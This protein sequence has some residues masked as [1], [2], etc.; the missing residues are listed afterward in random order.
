M[1]L[2]VARLE[3]AV[4]RNDPAAVRAE[5]RDASEAERKTASKAL[6]DLFRGPA[7]PDDLPV[8][9]VQPEDLAGLIASG[10]RGHAVAG[11]EHSERERKYQEWRAVANGLA[12]QL[13]VLG[14]S[15]GVA[16]AARAAQDFPHSYEMTDADIGLAA[17]LL[18]DRAPGWL[19]DLVDRHL[20]MHGQYQLGIPAWPLARKL[21][22]LGAITRPSV[23]EYTTLLPGGLLHRAVGRG[24]VQGPLPSPAQ[25]LLADPG[26]L[27]EEVWRLFTVPDAG[28][29]LEQ[30][31]R[32][33]DWMRGREWVPEQTW[34][35]SL[36]QLSAQGHLA[37]GR[38]IDACL[39]AFCRDF[40]PHR[41]SWYAVTLHQLGPSASE[42]AARQGKYLS[43]LAAGSKA[44]ISIGQQ[45]ARCLL[46]AGLLDVWRLL[47]ASA[48][49]LLF[50]QKS[51]AAAQLKLVGR[52]IAAAP[53]AQPQAVG[54]V[55]LAF[56]HERQD[57][58]E[59]ALAMIRKHGIPDGAPVA[60]MRSHAAGL[61]PSLAAEAAAL[62]LGPHTSSLASGTPSGA[63]D[64]GHLQPDTDMRAAELAVLQDRIR[65]LPGT[66]APGP[67]AALAIVTG[68]DVPGP[69]QVEAAAGS[70]LP[71]PVTDTGELIA[72]LTMLLEDAAD[73]IAVERALAGA[74]RLS[75]LPLRQ[76]SQAAAP[77]L[78]RAAAVMDIYTPFSG[79]RLTSDIAL[80]A[81]VW[82]S[83]QLPAEDVPRHRRWHMPGEFAVDSTGRAL[84][85]AGIF[86]ARAWEAARIIEAGHGGLLLAEP[87]SS[88]GA[89]TPDC[90]LERLQQL[91]HHHDRTGARQAAGYDRD[92][93]LLRLAPSPPNSLWDAW[94]QVDGTSAGTL[95]E[96]HR[97]LQT[98]LRFAAVTGE[99]GGRPL[100]G[101]AWHQH[102]LA[103]TA[104]RVPVTP[105]CAS[106]QLLTRLDDP[107]GDH[108]ELAG[109]SRYQRHYGAMVAGWTLACPWQPEL[110]AAH[111]LRPLCDGLR[112]GMSPATTAIMSLIDPGHP[113]GPVGHLALVT[114]LAS[115]EADT[116][117]AAAELWADAAADGRLQPALAAAAVVKGVTGRALK[118]NRI[119]D[120]L[121]LA[122][123][124]PLPA[125]RT[126][127]TICAATPGLTTTPPAGMHQLLELAAQ[128]AATTGTPSL[129][130]QLNQ[131]A[132]RRSRLGATARQLQHTQHTHA[133]G[134]KQAALDALAALIT[135]AESQQP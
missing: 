8:V 66:Q 85:M 44:G 24:H 86:S 58:Q 9:V 29:V 34:S 98:P 127:E 42:I 131:L 11:R 7:F 74:V 46:D 22:Q 61:A 68:G 12:F 4:R 130:P 40:S 134:Q 5:L 49:A 70:A 38:L 10:F 27:E 111:L 25:A 93:A 76:R 99:P 110:A 80:I 122:A 72:L 112:P 15:G 120:S 32:R 6:K 47:D 78:K 28:L 115:A 14:L 90:L 37:R 20:R 108:A 118:L 13:A 81:H 1:S 121:K 101:S 96:T 106:W 36:V 19:G 57:I 107:L 104:G 89:I 132:S 119:A 56:G 31:D 103:R 63:D 125:R 52:V 87:Q 105:G 33:A 95:R 126:V 51:V 123:H 88:R 65:A 55:A 77:L 94:E 62:G 116:R 60:Q 129:P 84:T 16:A 23:P 91:A 83:G 102:L 69:A 50:P 133:P 41:V 17:A 53:A 109:P 64:R 128:L 30:A 71:G 2:D 26:L 73:A 75:R 97:L 135:R 113:L 48:P 39:D 79:E 43:L 82:G 21:V 54:L 92:A 100:R 3:V 114:G 67:V 59:A 117:I 18:A 124:S 35:Q 45:G